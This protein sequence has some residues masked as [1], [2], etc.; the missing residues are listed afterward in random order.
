MTRSHV[1]IIILQTSVLSFSIIYIII[2]NGGFKAK[3]AFGKKK[4]IYYLL[5]LFW[6][7]NLIILDRRVSPFT[8][9]IIV[10]VACVLIFFS[11]YR[12]VKKRLCIDGKEKG[13]S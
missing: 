9:D 7:L 13:P 10:Y 12:R 5:F 8:F 11:I 4:A 2:R 6:V 3:N 1:D